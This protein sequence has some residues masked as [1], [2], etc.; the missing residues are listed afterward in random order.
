MAADFAFASVAELG[1]ALRARNAA[2]RSPSDFV[3]FVHR[4][5]L[6]AFINAR[7]CLHSKKCKHIIQALKDGDKQ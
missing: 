1:R 4:G 5:P 6:L 3:I 2:F 7:I